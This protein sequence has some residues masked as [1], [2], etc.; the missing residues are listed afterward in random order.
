MELNTKFISD[1]QLDIG[2]NGAVRVIDYKG[3]SL[4]SMEP[5]VKSQGDLVAVIKTCS[6]RNLYTLRSRFELDTLL[7]RRFMSEMNTLLAKSNT[8]L[9][10]TDYGIW[11]RDPT[12]TEFISTTPLQ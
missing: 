3:D 7:K 2:V 1:A 10:M 4:L 5:G 9:Q 11:Y 12:G 6:G 8:D